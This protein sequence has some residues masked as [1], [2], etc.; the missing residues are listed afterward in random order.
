MADKHSQGAD[1]RKAVKAAVSL[2]EG[3]IGDRNSSIPAK[4]S[5]NR[6]K[7][8]RPFK[9]RLSIQKNEA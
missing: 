9:E 6:N 3:V 1:F 2:A 7:P 5:R 4:A 8:A